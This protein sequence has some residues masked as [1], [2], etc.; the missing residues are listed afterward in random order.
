MASLFNSKCN[1]LLNQ[2][3]LSGEINLSFEDGSSVKAKQTKK[4][5][6]VTFFEIV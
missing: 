1:R 4:I 2:T 6:N 5:L 3:T